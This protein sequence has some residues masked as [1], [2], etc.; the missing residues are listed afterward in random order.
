VRRARLRLLLAGL[1]SGATQAGAKA[2]GWVPSHHLRL[3]AYR[4]LFRMSI[5]AGSTVYRAP[6][7]RKPSR[8]R[9]G[10]N[11]VIGN[12]AVLDGRGGL[13]IGDNVNF[14]SGVWVWTMQHDKDSAEFAAEAAPVVIGDRAWLSCRTTILPGVTIGPGAVVCAGAVVTSDVAPYAVVGGVPAKRIGE[15]SRDL[16][17][18][19]SGRIP[20]L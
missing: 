7:V 9:I 2:V 1:S 20:L 15:R 18:T 6:E 11:T 13:R 16:T 14:S 12:G 8:I 19:L 17:Y 10:R 4:K 5:G 3:L